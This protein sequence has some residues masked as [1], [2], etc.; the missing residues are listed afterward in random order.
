M[1]TIKSVLFV[2]DGPHSKSEKVAVRQLTCQALG[3]VDRVLGVTLPVPTH[4]W[5][6]AN[7]KIFFNKKQNYQ[8]Y[9]RASSKVAYT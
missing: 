6:V 8:K 4:I 1:K 3:K 5:G 9:S 7:D 2:C